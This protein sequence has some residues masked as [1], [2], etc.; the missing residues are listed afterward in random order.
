MIDSAARSREIF[1][2]LGGDFDMLP[3]AE[4]VYVGGDAKDPRRI[5]NEITQQAQKLGRAR[6]RE[7]FS[8]RN[9]S[10]SA[11]ETVSKISG[12]RK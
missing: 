4:Y 11:L 2:S 9:A 7:I 12:K 8:R 10:T 5:F 3:G 6:S 1:S